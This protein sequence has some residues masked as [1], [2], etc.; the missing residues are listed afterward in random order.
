M[1]KPDSTGRAQQHGRHLRIFHS[2]FYSP[3]YRSL[4]AAS[5]V[6]LFELIALF[7]GRNNGRLFLSVLDAERLC[8]FGSDATVTKAFKELEDHGLIAAVRR[9]SFSRKTAH[10]TSWRLTFIYT[11]G[12]PPSAEY[13]R[14]KAPAGTRAALRL[15]R[16]SECNLRSE[17]SGLSVHITGTKSTKERPDRSPLAPKSGSA[18][19]RSPLSME[20][21]WNPENRFVRGSRPRQAR[22]R[23]GSCHET[24]SFTN[25]NC[26]ASFGTR[27][28]E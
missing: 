15:L 4:G 24:H 3:A 19:L 7:N 23:S 28:D 12:H 17:F 9:G 21:Q 6:L 16:L 2:V 20:E 10:A 14:W 25:R 26:L 8:G 1:G 22:E 27:L 13:A 18:I 5:R 11:E